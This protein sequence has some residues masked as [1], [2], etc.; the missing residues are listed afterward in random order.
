M[1]Y[2]FWLKNESK[3]VFFV[4]FFESVRLILL[5]IANLGPSI[6]NVLSYILSRQNLCFMPGLTPQVELNNL[7]VHNVYL[8]ISGSAMSFF[9]VLSLINFKF[10]VFFLPPFRS[11]AQSNPISKF[12]SC[13]WQSKLNNYFLWM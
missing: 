3:K 10:F 1:K 11:P 6:W 5:Y 4:L 8:N 9:S 13:Y 7:F 12:L 2:L